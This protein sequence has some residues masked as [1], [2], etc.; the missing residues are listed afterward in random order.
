MLTFIRKLN[1]LACRIGSIVLVLMLLLTVLNMFLTFI[2]YPIKGAFELLGFLG[3]L[4][5]GMAISP[6]QAQKGHIRVN[7][8]DNFWSKK[9]KYIL[10]VISLT[11]SLAFFVI[12]DWQIF[13]LALELRE[14]EE[15]SQTLNIAFYPVVFVLGLGIALC[16]ITLFSQLINCKNNSLES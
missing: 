14:W 8:L 5:G 3:A 4:L 11:L 9:T 6:T 12:L 2:G 10:D 13:R 16:C 7:L 15:L 1:L